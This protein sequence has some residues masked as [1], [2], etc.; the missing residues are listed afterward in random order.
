[1]ARIA[2]TAEAFEAIAATM[3]LGSVAYQVEVTEGKAV[4]LA[5]RWLDKLRARG[6]GESY[7]DVIVQVAA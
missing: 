1:M 7:S 6:K 5:A 2:V 3:P 4:G